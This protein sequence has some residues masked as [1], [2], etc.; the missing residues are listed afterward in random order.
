MICST[1]DIVCEYERL[2][3]GAFSKFFYRFNLYWHKLWIGE[4]LNYTRAQDVHIL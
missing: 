1:T 4:C 2:N 3:W